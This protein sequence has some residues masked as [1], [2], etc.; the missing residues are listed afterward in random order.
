M[1]EASTCFLKLFLFLSGFLLF[2]SIFLFILLAKGFFNF[3]L[4]KDLFQRIWSRSLYCHCFKFFLSLQRFFSI[5]S[6]LKLIVDLDIFFCLDIRV[7]TG[8]FSLLIFFWKLIWEEALRTH[9]LK[10]HQ[11]CLFTL[12]IAFVSSEVFLSFY[13]SISDQFVRVKFW[14]EVM[15]YL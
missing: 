5:F 9:Q 10:D 3:S 15:P 7:F 6:G 14:L 1:V 4:I 8:F 12:I 2:Q 13:F 11:D